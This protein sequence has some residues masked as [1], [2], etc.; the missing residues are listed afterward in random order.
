MVFPYHFGHV[1]ENFQLLYCLHLE[2]GEERTLIHVVV[3]PFVQSQ[4]NIPA[5]YS[6]HIALL[7]T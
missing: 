2:N 5:Q 4:F 7:S 1:L 6:P 3:G